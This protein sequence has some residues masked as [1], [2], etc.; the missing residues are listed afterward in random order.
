M[1][2]KSKLLMAI[3]P[4]VVVPMMILGWIGHAYTR[5]IST[6]RTLSNLSV[7]LDQ[8]GQNIQFALK[9][10]EANLNQLS[11][12]PLLRKYLLTRDEL[13]RLA[14]M[15]P[16]LLRLFE[17]YQKAYP[18]YYEIRVLLPDG[19]EDAR[20]IVGH[21]PNATATEGQSSYFRAIQQIEDGIYSTF[22]RNPDNDKISLLIAKPL[23]LENTFADSIRAEPTVGGHLVLT[24]DLEFMERQVQQT[25]ISGAGQLF[26]TDNRGRILFQRHTAVVDNTLPAG[27]FRRLHDAAGTGE[28]VKTQYQGKTTLFQARQLHPELFLIGSLLE[29]ELLAVSKGLSGLVTMIVAVTIIATGAFM[30]VILQYLLVGPIEKLHEAIK[31]ICNGNL[32]TPV[33]IRASDE[34]GELGQA[35]NEMQEHLHQ[36]DA[37]A[38]HLAYHDTL[39]G[40]PNRQMLNEHLTHALVHAKRQHNKMALL[41]LDLDNFK[42]INDT[43]GHHVGDK[44]LQQVAEQ[45]QHCLREED[46]IMRCRMESTA[47]SPGA[48][49][50]VA[51]LGGD[52]FLIILTDLD[53]GFAAETVAKRIIKKL[54]KTV[55]LDQEQ[56]SISTSIGITLFPDDGANADVLIKH[57]DMAMYHAKKSGKNNYQFYSRSM[58]QTVAQKAAIETKLRE[59]LQREMLI[60]H[61]QPQIHIRTG[62]IV[63]FEALLRWQDPELGWIPPATFIPVAEDTGLIVPISEWVLREACQQTKSWQTLFGTDGI[64]ISVNVSGLHVSGTNLS[65]RIGEILEETELDPGNLDLELTE[66]SLIT[67]EEP[68]HQT[69]ERIKA[70]GVTLS[71]DD[72][73]TG[74]SSLSY[75]QRFPI[76]KLKIDRSFLS[77]LPFD[78]DDAAIVS[79][80]I[81]LGQ[82]LT[83]GVTAEG[84]ET[85][86]QLCFLEEK[87]CDLAQGFL[88]S[89][90]IP[91][92][93]VVKLLAANGKNYRSQQRFDPRAAAPIT[94]EVAG[95]GRT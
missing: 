24:V 25:H 34:I 77:N 57:A 78:K 19:Y 22:F 65:K 33:E 82:S 32:T 90:P 92:H 27:L 61:Y 88:F 14:L 9:M 26:F 79:A 50:I 31:A 46:H 60:L 63:G 11:N 7:V 49:P 69:L 13:E 6:T 86:Q 38:R 20:S 53:A 51:R 67:A 45:L 39:T 71:L 29:Q 80:I 15:Q 72:F 18:N 76:D 93:E 87:G 8:F 2:L 42:Q 37:K 1:R 43:F 10:A 17:S 30:L 73:G 70:L 48:A 91:A 81:A 59:A 16:T 52:E 85:D 58:Q 12:S 41:F 94:W 75:L 28:T 3:V 21:I 36:A 83:L 4:L 95:A 64:F 5:D 55:D 84:V 62:R 66:T 40:L 89:P 74:Y 54:S 47:G 44:L 68:A 35:F 56:L 23:H